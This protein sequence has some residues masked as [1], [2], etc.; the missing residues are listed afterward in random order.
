MR[1]RIIAALTSSRKQYGGGR[2]RQDTTANE[3]TLSPD[4]GKF[5]VG[6]FAS[7]RCQKTRVHNGN[8]LGFEYPGSDEAIDSRRH[9][10]RRRQIEQF[11]ASI[12]RTPGNINDVIPLQLEI[13]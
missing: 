1:C 13:A 5:P 8:F 12:K 6:Q 4:R 10:G 3:D 9:K 11:L 7:E 2:H